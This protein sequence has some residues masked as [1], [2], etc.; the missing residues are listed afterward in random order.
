MRSLSLSLLVSIA[1][2]TTILE[3]VNALS[4]TSERSHSPTVA[5]KSSMVVTGERDRL[6]GREALRLVDASQ[7]DVDPSAIEQ[8]IE[9][10]PTF[11]DIDEQLEGEENAEA[12]VEATEAAPIPEEAPASAAGSPIVKPAADQS[13]VSIQTKGVSEVLPLSAALAKLGGDIKRGEIAAKACAI[14]HSFKPGG[15]AKDGPNLY[16]I[17]GRRVGKSPSF[18]KY[19]KAMREH[20]GIWTLELL[21]CYLKKPKKCIPGSNMAFGGLASKKLRADVISYLLT[22]TSGE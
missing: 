3:S 21:D 18:D 16:K 2:M 12:E 7:Y 14:C 22:V 10:E 9:G 4:A 1:G 6:A 19:S 20:D 15:K 8:E 11:E 5:F 13:S 17:Y